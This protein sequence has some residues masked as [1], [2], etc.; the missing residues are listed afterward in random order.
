MLLMI[1][2]VSTSL[3]F[4]YCYFGK[5]ATDSLEGMA[6]CLF[7]SNWHELPIELQ[8]YFLIMIGNA[9]RKLHYHGFGIVRLDLEAFSKVFHR[10]W[11]PKWVH[12]LTINYWF[13]VSQGRFYV[14]HGFQ[15]H[16]RVMSYHYDGEMEQRCILSCQF[17][18]STTFHTNWSTV[19]TTALKKTMHGIDVI[20]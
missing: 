20:A 17:E 9:Q 15:N 10:I 18:W 13:S 19:E 3:L 2:V 16:H 7:E 1:T 5:I 6:D 12:R 14:L 4:F 11:I 8:K